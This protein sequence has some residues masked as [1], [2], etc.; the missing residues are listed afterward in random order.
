MKNNMKEIRN[1]QGI[2]QVELV[3]KTGISQGEISEI[4]NGKIV[5][6]IERTL[7]LCRAL[8]CKPD[9]LF[10]LEQEETW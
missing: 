5:P 3:M 1:R 6:G 2:T 8:D 7:I 4:E 10:Q 9:D